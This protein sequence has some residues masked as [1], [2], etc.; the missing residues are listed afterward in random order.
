MREGALI[1]VSGNQAQELL[2]TVSEGGQAFL[3]QG[4]AHGIG[5]QAQLFR[6]QPGLPGGIVR[7]AR[8]ACG[9]P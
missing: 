7:E 1:L 2:V 9:S 6:L 3:L 4:F 8:V 5:Q